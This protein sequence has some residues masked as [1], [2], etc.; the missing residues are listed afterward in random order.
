MIIV[1]GGAG[2][3]GSNLVKSLNNQGIS[4]ILVVDNLSNAEKVNNLSGLNIADYMDKDDF[5]EL[6]QGDV[7]SRLLPDNVTLVF[8]QGACSDTMVSDG[9]YVMRNNFTYSKLLF[10][11]C[12]LNNAQYIYASSASVYG[13][14][15]NLQG[16]P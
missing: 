10:Q 9:R 13:A 2:F 3:I 12:K 7:N 16:I 5:F 4:D 1:T 8:H 14:G 15:K 11:L 6:M